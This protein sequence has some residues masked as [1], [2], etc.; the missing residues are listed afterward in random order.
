MA[1]KNYKNSTNTSTLMKGKPSHPNNRSRS[2]RSDLFFDVV[3]V[4]V[5]KREWLVTRKKAG[6]R[7][8]W[9][10]SSCSN[11]AVID[12]HPELIRAKNN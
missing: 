12:S 5:E 9:T 1:V 8:D 3:D 7:D 6:I 2:I 11:E 4:A 10:N